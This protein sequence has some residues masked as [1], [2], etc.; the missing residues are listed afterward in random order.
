MDDLV[1]WLRA[2]LDEDEWIA[3]EAG[4]KYESGGRRW[5][6][7]R[8]GSDGTVGD[9]RGSVVVYR[10]GVGRQHSV[11]IA[12]H[13]PARVLREIDAKRQLVERYERAVENRRAHPEYLSSAGAHVALQ[14]A[15]KLLALP[16][17]DRPGY[18]EEWRP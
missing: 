10:T 6:D 8:F 1:Q 17:A 15:V 2:R 4:G 16:Y 5:E 12:R 14:A 9:E 18:R 13:D 3:R 7:E 11:H